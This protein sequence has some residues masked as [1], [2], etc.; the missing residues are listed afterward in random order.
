MTISALV[1]HCGQTRGLYIISEESGANQRKC[2]FDGHRHFSLPMHPNDSTIHCR[3]VGIDQF[4]VGIVCGTSFSAVAITRIFGSR[5]VLSGPENASSFLQLPDQLSN[6]RR[7]VHLHPDS[8]S[9]ISCFFF[10]RFYCI[11]L[12]FQ[13]AMQLSQIDLLICGLV[14]AVTATYIAFTRRRRG[15]L[16]P[17][18]KGLPLIG[19]SKQA[20][21]SVLREAQFFHTEYPRHAFS[22]DMGSI[23]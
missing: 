8:P 18:P 17:G 16:P 1:T 14:L 7:T 9:T 20:F 6:Q 19:V 15:P 21:W 22:K 2:N 10:V 4:N 5:E 13:P 12:S 3:V 11:H 23:W